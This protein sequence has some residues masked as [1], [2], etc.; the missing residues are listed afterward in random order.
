VAVKVDVQS[1]QVQIVVPVRVDRAV[2]GAPVLDA[3]D[4]DDRAFIPHLPSGV[5]QDDARGAVFGMMLD[6]SVRVRVTR[7]DMDAGAPLFA[8]A[9]ASAN[10]Q[11]TVTDP[12][13]GGPLPPSGEFTL[14]AIDD[15]LTPQKLEIRLGSATGPVVA[16]ASPHIFSPLTLNIT[17]H[18]VR[19][20]KAT[21][22]AGA[23]VFPTINGSP[24]ES[25]LDQLFD[26]ARAVWRPAGI[27]FNIGTVEKH[28]LLKCQND[29]R[30]SLGNE[31]EI[32]SERH[33]ILQKHKKSTCNIYFVVEMTN[34]LGIG[35][36]P[37]TQPLENFKNP[38]VIVAIR[39]TLVTGTNGFQFTRPS[40]GAGLFQEI[41]N[42]V[43]HEIGHFVSLE[44]ADNV[45]GTG[46]PD[47]YNRRHL[48]HANN[49][50]GNAN[51]ATAGAPRFD[52]I[53]YGLT[54]PGGQGH[55]GCLLTLK[56]HPKHNTNP[57]ITHARARVKNPKKLFG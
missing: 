56:Q 17:P 49:P 15:N 44:H 33:L 28:E 24:L 30:T 18:I 37:D 23:G 35:V 6:E 9:G 19:L 14:K 41:G 40:T 38:A 13:G 12:V 45:H 22:G 8:V 29:D 53:G 10:P 5:N 25:V 27:K 2:R 46:P 7:D 39:G 52:D 11:F 20:S 16:E 26:V 34:K 21:T 48:M 42:D 31:S 4:V 51:L 57:D 3:P 32:G 36:R 54:T 55:R 1:G 43:S 47:T 50:L